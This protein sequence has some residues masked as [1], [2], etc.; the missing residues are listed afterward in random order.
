MLHDYLTQF[1]G[2]KLSY[3]VL[4]LYYAVFKPTST[5]FIALALYL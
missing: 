2:A 5:V 4:Y 1:L 3:L